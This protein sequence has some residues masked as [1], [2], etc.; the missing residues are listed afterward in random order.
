MN[1]NE[2]SGYID[3]AQLAEDGWVDYADDRINT[4][5]DREDAE[6]HAEKFDIEAYHREE[7]ERRTKLNMVE[8][9]K[10]KPLKYML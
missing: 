2:D 4:H 1:L 5:D 7:M 10:K 6:K 3:G 9:R 8:K